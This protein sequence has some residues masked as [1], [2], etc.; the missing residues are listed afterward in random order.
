M[1]LKFPTHV[2]VAITATTL[3]ASFASAAMSNDD[4]DQAAARQAYIDN[5]FKKIDTNHDGVIDQREW[6]SFMTK[7]LAQQQKEF[8]GSFDAADTNHDGKLSRA[9]A[10]AANPLLVRYFDQIDTN[11]DGY[12]SKAQIRSAIL[13][14]MENSVPQDN[15]AQ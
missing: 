7:Y 15:A 13:K 4:A 5:S 1:N 12:L 8:D 10:Q 11:H 3:V 2:A 14:K 9:E 6:N